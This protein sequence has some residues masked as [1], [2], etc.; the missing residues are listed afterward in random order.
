MFVPNFKILGAAVPKKSLTQ[1]SL[2]I[3]MELDIEKA[4]KQN[5]FQHHCFLLHII[6]QPSVRVYKI[7]RLWLSQELRNLWQKFYYNEK[8]VQL[9]GMI[10]MKMLT[11]LTQYNWLYP[12]FVTNFNILGTVVSEKSLTQI[13]L[14]I[15]LKWEM[16]KK[17]R[18]KNGIRR[19]KTI[20]HRSFLL[21]N[22]LQPSLCVYKIWRFWLT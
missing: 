20:Q 8:N 19:Q 21:H 18:E 9:K 13:S 17:K 16:E 3:A 14:C 12:T 2:C 1:T 7:W 15:T 6:L 10:C 4:K 22:K 5:K 11:S